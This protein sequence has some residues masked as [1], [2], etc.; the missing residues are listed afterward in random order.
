MCVC[1]GGG[2]VCACA[3]VCVCVRAC[4]CNGVHTLFYS[5]ADDCVEDVTFSREVTSCQSKTM[6]IVNTNPQKLASC[7]FRSS[8]LQIQYMC[9]PG[10]SILLY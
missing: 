6:C 10:T 3:C 4:V 7:V 8:F 5:R 2:G 9:L 1:V